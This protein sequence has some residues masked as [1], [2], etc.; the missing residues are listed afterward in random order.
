[1]G[2]PRP[3]RQL[4]PPGLKGKY[5]GSL[6]GWC[7]SLLNPLATL[8]IYTVVFSDDLPGRAANMGNGHKGNYTL[9]LF[10]GL[11]LWNFFFGVVTGSMGSLIGAGPLLRKIYFPPAAPVAGSM[12][13]VLFQTGIE[14]SIVVI[15]MIAIGNNSWTVV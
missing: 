9:F 8:A 14:T 2:V 6:L 11:I 15:I 12:L 3:G 13:A 7:W 4:R 5:K 1:V 10:C